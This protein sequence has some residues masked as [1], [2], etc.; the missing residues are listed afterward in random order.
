MRQL[1]RVTW[2]QFMARYLTFMTVPCAKYVAHGLRQLCSCAFQVV[3]LC[4]LVDS[5]CI[6][7]HR[8][9]PYTFAR[10]T[11]FLVMGIS[12]ALYYRLGFRLVGRWCGVD[13]VTLYI[14]LIL[15]NRFW[16]R[17]VINPGVIGLVAIMGIGYAGVGLRTETN[18]LDHICHRQ[19]SIAFY[20][21][22][23]IGEPEFRAWG[24]GLLW[25]L[26]R[27]YRRWLAYDHRQGYPAR[28]LL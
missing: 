18:N 21:G 5:Y 15:V 19:D 16:H 4:I 2:R 23:V 28:C 17:E 20:K 7:M 26:Q 22:I 27:T 14:V 1:L 9:L 8:W 6:C 13:R 12:G 25:R 10:I 11:F 3:G 24:N